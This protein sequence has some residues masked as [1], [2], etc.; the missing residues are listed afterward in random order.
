VSASSKRLCQVCGTVL[1]GDNESCPVC[2]L[3]DALTPER[4]S[5]SEISELRF[6][7]YTVLQNPDGTPMELGRGAMGVTYKAFDA[8]LQC[9]VALKII[10]ARLIGDSSARNRFVKEARAAA[11]VRHQ[12]VASVFHL[13]ESGGNYFYAMEFVAGETL[14]KM[15]QRSGRLEPKLALDIVEQVATGLSAI[16]KQHLVHRDIK[17]SNIMVNQDDGHLDG[18]K[19]IDL[20]LVKGV[21]EERSIST[22]GSFIGTPEY[23][24]PE[25][26]AGVGGRHSFRSVLAWR[27]PLGDA[28]RQ[29]CLRRFSRRV[30]VQTPA[31]STARR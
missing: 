15:I 16:Q 4:G 10:N 11:S 8:H 23:A 26:F 9:P 30:D 31:R 24:S 7:H 3:Q 5:A 14:E 27:D 6:E 22:L 29:A 18:V 12:N 20:G 28:H 21:A 2:A 13:G 19:I 25:Q 17:P 1:G